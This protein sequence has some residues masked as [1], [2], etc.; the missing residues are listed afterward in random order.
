MDS[1]LDCK[2]ALLGRNSSAGTVERSCTSSAC[3]VGKTLEPAVG[4]RR[5]TT[6]GGKD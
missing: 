3:F 2:L 4:M 1:A 5:T 6:A